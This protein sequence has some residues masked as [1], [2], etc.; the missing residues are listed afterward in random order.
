MPLKKKHTT[1][2]PTNV[3]TNA[4]NTTKTNNTNVQ[5]SAKINPKETQITSLNASLVQREV[6]RLLAYSVI[7][8]KCEILCYDEKLHKSLDNIIEKL[9]SLE[10]DIDST[11]DE[12]ISK[13]IERHL[14]LLNQRMKLLKFLSEKQVKFSSNRNNITKK[15]DDIDINAHC[16][17]CNM[18]HSSDNC[19]VFPLNRRSNIIKFRKRCFKCLE[20]LTQGHNCGKKCANCNNGH[21]ISL[22]ERSAKGLPPKFPENLTS[23][24]K[25]LCEPDTNMTLV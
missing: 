11:P 25:S 15:Q 14:A 6:Q 21:H 2:I 8:I 5:V 18:D 22:C 12:L 20:K 17:F 16:I 19:L 3:A 4:T 10:Q 13:I 7:Y 9:E 23:S 24:D 1:K